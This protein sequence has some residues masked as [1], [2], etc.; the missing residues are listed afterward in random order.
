MTVVIPLT[1]WPPSA[2]FVLLR[3]HVR[4]HCTSVA[5][6]DTIRLRNQ[7]C[8]KAKVSVLSNST[9]I[10]KPDVFN[11][12]LQVDNN[13]LKLDTVSEEYIR[14]VD[15]PTGHYDLNR[16]IDLLCAFKGKVI[17]QT[18]FMKGT[19]N[20]KSVDNTGDE[21]VM[22]WLEVVRRIAPSQVMVYTIDRETPDPDLQKASH[23]ELDR[24]VALVEAAGIKASASY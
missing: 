20:G 6:D 3:S 21:Y 7:Y 12:L 24:I 9:F 13:I 19:S 11:A 10:I 2:Q 23:E 15:R 4:T 14:K 18:L 5:S 1:T 16:I 8:P 17:I 22:P